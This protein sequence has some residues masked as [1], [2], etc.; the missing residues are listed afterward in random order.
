[1]EDPRNVVYD[2]MIND[3]FTPTDIAIMCLRYMSD[4]DV[5]KMIREKDL[6]EAV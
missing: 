1:M 3:V 6:M 2:L 4:E 5:L